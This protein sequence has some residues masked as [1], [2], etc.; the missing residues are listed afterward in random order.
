M[1]II[2]WQ[3]QIVLVTLLV[4]GIVNVIAYTLIREKDRKIKRMQ[5]GIS[6]A[7]DKINADSLALDNFNRDTL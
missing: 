1:L 7:I 2:E 4:S 6:L 3:W 5:E